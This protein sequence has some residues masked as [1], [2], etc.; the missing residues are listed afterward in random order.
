MKMWRIEA[1]IMPKEGVNDPQGEAIQGGL[2]SLEFT[3]VR[4]V[5]AGKIIAIE[6]EAESETGALHQG[7]RMCDQ[8]LANPVI[9]SY[10]LAATP[11]DVPES[12][13]SVP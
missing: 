11:L 10:T 6:V 13:G 2:N 7:T 9:E 5:R 3:T 1:T 8:L 4:S 12:T